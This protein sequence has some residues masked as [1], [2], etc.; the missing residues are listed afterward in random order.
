MAK[1]Q[2]IESLHRLERTLLPALSSTYQQVQAFTKKTKLSSTEVRRALQWLEQKNLVETKKHTAE[3]LQ[4]GGNGQHYLKKGLPEKV[5]LVDI[6]KGTNTIQ[7]LMI[8]KTLNP[9]EITASIGVLKQKQYIELEKGEIT[10]TAKGKKALTEM[11]PEEI[12]LKEIADGKTY[13]TL[14]D[15]EK[16]I[17]QLLQSKKRHCCIR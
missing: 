6:E 7:K 12:F 17:F 14:N 16:K 2:L 8:Q 11:W 1:K 15:A 5:V 9:Q 3:L 4:L 10:V 13:E